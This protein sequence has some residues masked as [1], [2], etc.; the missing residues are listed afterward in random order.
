MKIKLIETLILLILFSFTFSSCM[1]NETTSSSSKIESAFPYS[2]GN[3]SRIESGITS[4]IESGITSEIEAETS[5]SSSPETSPFP[6][7]AAPRIEGVSVTP[8]YASGN[9]PSYD[10]ANPLVYAE[11]MGALVKIFVRNDNSTGEF[12]GQVLFNSKTAGQLIQE[13]IVTWADT[14]DLRGK[15]N[16]TTNI[17]A[18]SMDVYTLNIIDDRFY[19]DG[20][21][22]RFTNSRTGA[23]TTEKIHINEPKV[24]S[25]RITFT[26]SK[27][28]RIPD[29][30]LMYIEN[31]SDKEIIVDS[32]NLWP[33]SGSVST[34]WWEKPLTHKNLSWF[35]V[36]NSIK[37]N[38]MSGFSLQT[39]ILAF[40]ESIIEVNYKSGG[41]S[42]KLI[43]LIKPVINEFDISMG[44]GSQ[45]LA[46]S[47]AFRKT[48][49]FMHFNTVHGGSDNYFYQ[50]DILAKYPM[51][52]FDT[53]PY[54][55]NFSTP[56]NLPFVHASERFGEP[57]QSNKS[58]Q[59]I[60]DVYAFYRMSGYPT[61]LTL[62]HEPGFYKYA[63]LVDYQHFDAYRI[64]AP[65]ADRWGTYTKY[66]KRN[67]RG[68]LNVEQLSWGAPL[69]TIGDYMRTLNKI[70]YPN[71]VAAWTQGIS[72][73]WASPFG[74]NRPSQSNSF[75]TR[76]QAYQAIAN[77]A[78]SLYWFNISGGSAAKNRGSL[79]EIQKINRE[80]STVGPLISQT[81]PFYWKNVFMDIDYNTLAGPD[82]AIL[83]V[84]DLKYPVSSN[85]YI[86]AGNRTGPFMLDLPLY[87][88][89]SNSAI[90]VGYDGIKDVP[91][92]VKN[93]KAKI[94]DTIKD[95]GIYIVYNSENANYRTK[96]IQ[97]Y[98]ALIEK[99]KSYKF[100]PITNDQDFDVLKTQVES[101]E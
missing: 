49:K 66:G 12:Q 73:G 20:I 13:G 70:S 77:G 84:T 26:S 54:I 8:H 5:T 99:E 89:N 96:L 53:L 79:D 91:I 19:K 86:S 62:N 58:A 63:G 44:W 14:P 83:F 60:Y 65:H 36:S 22:I 6:N 32:V 27:N 95:T 67:I 92:T 74:V 11:N 72:N 4:R 37:S 35:G 9:I 69:E 16:F 94:T 47:E 25:P 34:H 85:Q 7:S 2:Q 87:L 3:K 81:V 46:G 64:N 59:E 51:K 61:T 29:G 90:K 97:S 42:Q 76:I 101:I 45:F 1:R 43:Y 52:R 68:L 55:E 71:P 17:P 38:D 57:Q 39:G 18:K 40:G 75:E 48:I 88:R 33:S 80:F 56:Q 23:V 82:F 31:K 15:L 50:S 28:N 98:L 100:N 21:D 93:G 10:R 41:K 24:L 78:L 30:F